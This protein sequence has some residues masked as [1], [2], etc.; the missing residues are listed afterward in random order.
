MSFGLP[1]TA[2]GDS[3]GLEEA[4]SMESKGFLG[5]NHFRC[6]LILFSYTDMCRVVV[7]GSAVP[8]ESGGV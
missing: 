8:A 3:A 1:H 2:L 7:P 4:L 6:I 5:G